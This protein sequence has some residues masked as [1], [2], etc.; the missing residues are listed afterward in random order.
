M[1]FS[2]LFIRLAVYRDQ[3]FVSIIGRTISK[4]AFEG[5]EGNGC[6]LSSNSS[7]SFCLFKVL[8]IGPA[9]YLP[10]KM[11]QLQLCSGCLLVA[12]HNC[13]CFTMLF[14]LSSIVFQHHLILYYL[15]TFL[16]FFFLIGVSKIHGL[17]S[18]FIILNLELLMNWN[19]MKPKTVPRVMQSDSKLECYNI[20]KANN[21]CTS[22]L[23]WYYRKW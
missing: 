1:Q 18:S 14:S 12:G 6:D 23:L 11:I 19:Y 8:Y 7:P 16:P 13:S 9:V 15:F 21:N 5:V 17:I 2:H 20:R 10:K 3:L 22:S 4:G